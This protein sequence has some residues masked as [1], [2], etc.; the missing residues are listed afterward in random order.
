M[1]ILVIY[2]WLFILVCSGHL[3]VKYSS[4]PYSS[5]RHRS[6]ETLCSTQHRASEK[7]KASLVIFDKDGTL[8]CFHTMWSPWAQNLI[9]KYVLKWL[10]NTCLWSY[11]FLSSGSS[12]IMKLIDSICSIFCVILKVTITYLKKKN[13]SE[14]ES[15]LKWV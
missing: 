12:C 5:E 10:W 14:E 7:R 2:F 3:R 6:S 9:S 4:L 11:F 1:F 8:I 13:D 15:L